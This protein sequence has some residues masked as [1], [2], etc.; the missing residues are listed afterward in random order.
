MINMHRRQR[1]G[2]RPA[3]WLALALLLAAAL[4]GPAAAAE[5]GG[6]IDIRAPA[7]P[8]PQQL[9]RMRSW[10]AGYQRATE[11]LRKPLAA[12]LK[13][14][15]GEKLAGLAEACDRLAAALAG[16]DMEALFPVPDYATS[17]HLEAALGRL[18]RAA[19]ACRADRHVEVGYQV[20]EARRALANAALALRRFGLAP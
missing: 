19:A 14:L 11:P 1:L 7:P 13:G 15:R 18:G 20:G 2:L 6:L 5:G 3:G 16:L 12:L 17:V 4:A 8:D 9:A 10:H